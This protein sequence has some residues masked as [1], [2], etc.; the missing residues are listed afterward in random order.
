MLKSNIADIQELTGEIMSSNAGNNWIQMMSE[1]D[2]SLIKR[3]ILR[4]GS[5]KDMAKEY[6]VSY[7]TIRLRLD[8]LIAKIET[9]EEEIP[10]EFERH[11]RI[12]YAEGKIDHNTLKE[13][14]KLHKKEMKEN[15]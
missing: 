2:I 14:L 1:E 3:F 5:L 9:L 11:L 6:G 8:R 13:L 7:P 4:S 15:K 12:K 10:S